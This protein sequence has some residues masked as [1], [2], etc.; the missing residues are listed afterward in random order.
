M[1]IF[2]IFRSRDK[3]KN[4][5]SGSAFSFFLGASSAG[6]RVKERSAMQM[7]AVYSCVR[8]L[9]EAV[10]SLPLHFYEIKD[11]GSKEKAVDHPLY[12][13][14]HDEQ[15]S[16]KENPRLRHANPKDEERLGEFPTT[17]IAQKQFEGTIPKRATYRKQEQ[18]AQSNKNNCNDF[19]V[20]VQAPP[21]QSVELS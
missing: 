5:T 18:H 20:Q 11:G 14:L 13:L 3:P 19:A 21:A 2:S 7:T 9:S 10:A 15:E 4:A 16:Q 6:K 17:A 12:F 1:D 8:I